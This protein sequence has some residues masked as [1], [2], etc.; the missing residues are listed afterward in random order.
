MAC[1][2]ISRMAYMLSYTRADTSDSSK[3]RPPQTQLARL[4]G[5]PLCGQW[6]LK[7]ELLHPDRA[8]QLLFGKAPWHMIT[9][10][11]AALA[12]TTGCERRAEDGDQPT[13]PR[14]PG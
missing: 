4:C 10:C 11:T 9:L 14:S 13:D 6:D 5:I 1:T 8:C 7:R 2:V 12:A 3:A